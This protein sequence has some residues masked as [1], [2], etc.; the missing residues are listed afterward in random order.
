MMLL[1]LIKALTSKA[2]LIGPW[3]D[4]FWA[5]SFYQKNG[6]RILGEEEMNSLLNTFWSIPER[7]VETSLVL[8]SAN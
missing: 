5:I 7:Q 1:R 3:A 2:I 6:F 8:A 4:A